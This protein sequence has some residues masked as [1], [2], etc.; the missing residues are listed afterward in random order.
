M[1]LTTYITHYL[2]FVQFL[3]GLTKTLC[4]HLHLSEL[5]PSEMWRWR[6]RHTK[7]VSC[8]ESSQS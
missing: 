1:K 2:L 3:R 8:L 6:R 5:F 4:K 7:P